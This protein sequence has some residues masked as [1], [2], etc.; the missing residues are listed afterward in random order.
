VLDTSPR[1]SAKIY[2][3]PVQVRRNRIGRPLPQPVASATP[4]VVSSGWYHDAAIQES[5]RARKA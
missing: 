2:Q 5:E 1:P 3:F 4:V